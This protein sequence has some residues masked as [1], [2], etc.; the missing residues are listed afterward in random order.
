[1]DND[2]VA[3]DNDHNVVP[4]ETDEAAVITPPKRPLRTRRKPLPKAG[5]PAEEA[6]P[7]AAAPVQP[8]QAPEE[9]AE[10]AAPEA[11]AKAPARR[12]R[13]RKVAEPAEPLPAF[14]ADGAT[15]TAAATSQPAGDTAAG[16][17]AAEAAAAAPAEKPVRRRASRA[18]AAAPVVEPAAETADGQAAEGQAAEAQTAEAQPAE[19]PA[20]EAAAVPAAAPVAEPV[21][22]EAPAAAN[23][24]TETPAA[25]APAAAPSLFMEPGA[26]TSMIFQAPDLTAVV[27]PAPAAAAEAEDD[28]AEA[29]SDDDAGNRRRRRSRGRR[30]RSGRAG[31]ES[32]SDTD[33]EDNG[34]ES[35]EVS[36]GALE[37]GVTSRRRRRRRRGDQDLELTGGGDDDPPNTVTRVRAPRAAAEAPVSNRV[38]SLKGSTRLEA[39]KQRRRESRDTGRRRTVITE[40]EFLARR[41]SVDR[42]MI[43]RQRD[44]RIQIGV[45]EDGVLAEHFVSKT[46]QDSLIGNVY[47]GKVQNVLPSMEA[48]FVDI[49][50]GRN[51]VLYAGE[52]NWDSV[53]LE[54]KQRRIENALKSG[55]SVLVQVTKDPVGHKGARLTS[56]ISLPGRYLVYVP[57]GSMTGIS[58]KL[59]DVERNRLKRILKDRLPEDAGVIVRTAAEGASEEELTHDINRL[60]AQWEGIE[61]QSTSTKIL[62]PE[63]LYGEPDL[64]IKVVRDVFNE[65]FSKLIVSGE[66]AWDTIEAY[67]TYVAP[68]LVGRLEKWTKDTDIF[69]AWRIDEQ[70]H[71]A[72][73][74]K[75]FLPSGGSLVIDRTEAMT[76]VDVNTGKF[77]GSGGNL[78]ETV[79]KNNLEAAEE[80]VRQL[81]LRDIGGIIV[82]DFID[83]VLESNRDLVL[84]RMV[85][86]LGRD[87]TKHQVAEVTS[88]G[89]VQM[90]RKR[91]GT[92][93]LEVFG[94]QCE[95]CAGR[96]IVTHDEP[97]EHRR[98]NVVA[99]E[100][101]VPRTEQQQPAARTERKSRRRGRGGQGAE[102]QS[103]PAAV[104][105]EPTEAERHAK[106][107]ATRAALANIAA[108][109]HAAHLH[110]GEAATGADAKTREAA[111]EAAVE[112]AATE[113][114]AG[115]PA[116]VLTF[117]GEQVALPFVEHADEA[118]APALTLDLLTEAFAH[119]GAAEAAPAAA[120]AAVSEPAAKEPAGKEQEPQAPAAKGQA[121]QERPAPER[122]Q[123]RTSHEPA[124]GTSSR[125][126]RNRS[127]SR[128][129]GAANETSVEQRQET[130]QAAAGSVHE[131]KAP[132]AAA[133]AAKPAASE[134]IILGVGVPAS[135]L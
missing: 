26:V 95:A 29:E 113:E 66:E 112:L 128:A 115:R 92:G 49:G 21:A 87:R 109:A 57:G 127:A 30:G 97:V 38:T 19:T 99:A 101:H 56:Q 80:V 50:R 78:E 126:R 39:K 69:S 6:E 108:A 51:A 52:V 91:M 8:G 81:R 22:E 48:A 86:C 74:R 85:E 54:G 122:T 103:A 130:R 4:T 20:V 1:M 67:V 64:T 107:E 132:A 77:T 33:A 68:D 94:E 16:T 84:R 131:A 27:R 111:M 61:G 119:L 114:A 65:D 37:E 46:Q 58:R 59:P 106:A 125:G 18:K 40:A 17:E 93:L 43:V 70:I 47:L 31:G 96:G 9:S 129:Q 13:A 41:E 7:V 5:T 71:K 134:P 10:A 24:A 35:D 105:A 118:T 104:H 79:T 102:P 28:E 76:V 25:E 53:N 34:D 36:E 55:D 124:A 135:E 82:I 72:L 121:L 123:E 100:H 44:D 117:G 23:T 14:A 98:A 12:S 45:L 42:Q 2:Q 62:A 133:P 11:K 110:D 3:T 89:L 73:D 75:V 116:A 60:R 32:E 90:T 120:E 83:M 88:L 15:D 63:L